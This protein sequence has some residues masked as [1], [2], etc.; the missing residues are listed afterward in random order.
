[1]TWQPMFTLAVALALTAALPDAVRSQD[2]PAPDIVKGE[3]AYR[4]TGC[5][6]CHGTV[7]HG[8]AWQGPKLAPDPLPYPLFLRQLRQPARSMPPYREDVLSDA[9]VAN[10]YAW[11]KTIPRGKSAR[12][13]GL[14][15][16]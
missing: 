15:G 4:E 7:G 16:D 12:D 13:T 10:I 3:K 5:Y 2:A 9:E 1:M 8:G 6:A 14:L 11:L